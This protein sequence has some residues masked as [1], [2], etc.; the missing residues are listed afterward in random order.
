MS[1]LCFITTE[2]DLQLYLVEFIV[3]KNF[4]FLFLFGGVNFSSVLSLSSVLG[5]GCS[6]HC[7]MNHMVFGIGLMSDAMHAGQVPQPLAIS[8]AQIDS[9]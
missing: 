8:L 9:F 6:Q 3:I 5:V 2:L 4:T 7:S 1:S